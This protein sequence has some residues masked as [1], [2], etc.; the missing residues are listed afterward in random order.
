MKKDKLK[1]LMIPAL[2]AMTGMSAEAVYSWSNE[3]VKVKYG[4]DVWDTQTEF[5]KRWYSNI[6]MTERKLTFEI[7]L[8]DYINEETEI[9]DINQVL[10]KKAQLKRVDGTL[11]DLNVGIT[12]VQGQMGKYSVLVD[13]V[14]GHD[15]EEVIVG[16]NIKE[17][18]PTNIPVKNIQFKVIRDVTNP[19]IVVSGVE[20]G[21]VYNHNI[22][23]NVDVADLTNVKATT[24]VKRSGTAIE[25][26]LQLTHNKGQLVFNEDGNYEVKIIVNDE[27]GNRSETTNEFKINTK[28]PDIETTLASEYANAISK[29]V[30]ISIDDIN[31]LDL[32]KSSVAIKYGAQ[33]ES[34]K[35]DANGTMEIDLSSYGNGSISLTIN[36]VDI[37]GEIST[38]DFV[39]IYDDINPEFDIK[40]NNNVFENNKVYAEKFDL[41]FNSTDINFKDFEVLSATI[42]GVSTDLRLENL[43]Q[44]QSKLSINKDGAYIIKLVSNDKAGNKVEKELNFVLDTKKPVIIASENLTN[45]FFTGD[46]ELIFNVK[47]HQLEGEIEVTA[48]K[49]KNDKDTTG[50][51]YEIADKFIENNNTYSLNH[52]FTENGRYEITIKAEDK[53]NRVTTETFKFKLDKE[54]PDVQLI[55]DI[56]DNAYYT[57]DKSIEYTVDDN[58]EIASGSIKA[59]GT[60]EI[61]YEC[62]DNHDEHKST[63]N[64]GVTYRKNGKYHYFVEALD[65]AG[66]KGRKEIT[67]TIDK[68]APEI[69]IKTGGENSSNIKNGGYINVDS[70]KTEIKESNLHEFEYILKNSNGVIINH[71]NPTT[72]KETTSIKAENLKDD[73]YTLEVKA[74]DKILVDNKNRESK[75]VLEF[76]VDTTVPEVEMTGVEN[77]KFYNTDKVLKVKAKDLDWKEG[78]IKV[79]KDG[80]EF[81]NESLTNDTLSAFNFNKDGKYVVSLD[82]VDLAGNKVSKTLEFIIDKTNPLIIVESFENNELQYL[83]DLETLKV[84]I[85]EDNFNLDSF[86]IVGKKVKLDG[87][88]EEKILD[89]ENVDPTKAN[90]VKFE[91]AKEHFAEGG[92][93]DENGKYS[94]TIVEQDLAGNKSSKTINF[95]IDS[96]APQ[97]EIKGLDL[98]SENKHYNK[99]VAIDI[100]INDLYH[101]ENKVELLKDGKV[102]KLDGLTENGNNKNLK[103]NLNE[104][105]EY[106]LSVTSKD[107]SKNE[108]SK[109]AKFVIDKTATSLQIIDKANLDGQYFSG[110]K[111]VTVIVEDSHFNHKDF[112]L[113]VV[114]EKLG[115]D[116]HDQKI[117]LPFDMSKSKVTK[118]FNFA[119][120]ARHTITLTAKDGAGNVAKEE[121]VSFVIDKVAPKISIKGVE[122][123]QHYNET[124][125]VNIEIFDNNQNINEVVVTRNGVAYNVG[126][127]K[128]QG[129]VATLNHSFA[130]EGEYSIKVLATDKAGNKTTNNISFT[131]DKTAPIIIPKVSGTDQV[132][133]DGD[134]INKVFKPVF[135]LTDKNDKI[136]SIT[137]NGEVYEAGNVPILSQETEYNCIVKASDKAGNKAEKS[138]SFTIDTTVPKIDISGVASGFFNKE[139]TPK[140]VLE[141]KNLDKENSFAKLNGK[142]FTSGTKLDKDDYY[143][144][145]IKGQDLANNLNEKNISFVLDRGKPKIVFEEA[146]SGEYF[147][148][149]FIPKFVIEDLTDYQIV[150]MLLNG[151]NYEMGEM[152]TTEGKNVL[153]IEVK[154][155]AGNLENLTMEFMLDKTAPEFIINGIEDGEKYNGPVEATIKLKDPSDKLKSVLV[156]GKPANGDIKKENGEE[157]M[158]LNF[159]ELDDYEVELIAVDLAGNEKKETIKFEIVSET[160]LAKNNK[161]IMPLILGLGGVLAAGSALFIAKK[162]KEN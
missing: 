148:E 105:G 18:N 111:G 123:G 149:D 92:F 133:E 78:T 76:T 13:L 73:K 28:G 108:T 110:N 10:D 33:E 22:N 122:E 114:H 98:G 25:K 143:S 58:Y 81:I 119:D 161:G 1:L 56:V 5:S 141:D 77:D 147:T 72:N 102:Y 55:T 150:S 86:S 138:F 36:A 156:N 43:G 90:A 45:Q 30:T 11:Q 107:K 146:I 159:K 129:N 12:P 155:K 47:E 66:N 16:I 70:V 80:E 42:D 89:C 26:P 113:R 128:S 40:A 51:I 158:K 125:S 82:V 101:N 69:I 152:I 53:A 157:V 134:F 95:I 97:V 67:F 153:F 38:K 135:D 160:L 154:D 59:I 63:K 62:E 19:E 48:K 7:D 162:K 21:Q 2:V 4:E 20:N 37:L 29:N 50:E 60:E 136:D 8:S 49:Y 23:L 118:T 115:V 39:V 46:K 44:G 14:A 145:K 109:K 9:T 15:R 75:E 35:F 17:N 68:C 103:I 104:E 79:T 85:N 116:G 100:N 117:E 142:D 93:F 140:Y 99:N 3:S 65:L 91:I 87:T 84:Q 139:I 112:N 41:K 27:V 94:V 74:S 144:L 96:V 88:E 83:K 52:K 71:S 31:G 130:S 131:I 54:A 61:Q 120:D 132:I 106:V 121:K 151:E 126:S 64:N 6:K 127:I 57:E 24:E 137:L 124:K 34:K 32:M